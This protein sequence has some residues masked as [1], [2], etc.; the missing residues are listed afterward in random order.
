MT[1]HSLLRV[2]LKENQNIPILHTLFWLQ[3]T[4]WHKELGHYWVVMVLA[5]FSWNNLASVSERL[6]IMIC[7]LD[8]WPLPDLSLFSNTGFNLDGLLFGWKWKKYCAYSWSYLWSMLNLIC[9]QLYTTVL[10]LYP[11]CL[12]F[13]TFKVQAMIIWIWHL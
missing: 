6:M 8:I 11:K 5:K 12:S 3:I 10:Y 13:I 2:N 4:W 7:G 1:C 9:L